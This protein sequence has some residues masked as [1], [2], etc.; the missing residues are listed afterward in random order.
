MAM[1][2]GINGQ[3]TELFDGAKIDAIS[4]YTAGNGVQ[5]QGRTNGVQIEAGKV[6]ELIGSEDTGIGGSSYYISTA[7]VILSTGTSLASVS[8]KKGRYFLSFF[9][10]FQH[11]DAAV[12]T[13]AYIIKMGTANISP[14]ILLDKAQGMM[15]GYFS[16]SLPII[17]TTDD[18][19]IELTGAVGGLTGAS[20]NN[21]SII[22]GYRIA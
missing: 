19:L 21:M 12:R 9:S 20:I 5:L 16:L 7:T 14:S 18:T 15:Y 22:S 2:P 8:L 6:G 3:K 10:N 11:G 13:A 17:V 1:I 4:E